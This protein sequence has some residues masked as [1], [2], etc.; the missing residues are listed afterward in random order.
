MP[1]TPA[2]FTGPWHRTIRAIDW[3]CQEIP[4]IRVRISPPR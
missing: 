3:A 1:M 4:Q 2:S